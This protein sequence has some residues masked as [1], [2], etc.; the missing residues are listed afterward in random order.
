[1]L[2]HTKAAVQVR[3]ACDGTCARGGQDPRADRSLRPLRVGRA[4]Q[5]SVLPVV[6]LIVAGPKRQCAGIVCVAALWAKK[7]PRSSDNTPAPVAPIVPPSVAAAVQLQRAG[8]AVRV[9]VFVKA[10]DMLLTPSRRSSR[11]RRRCSAP[12]SSCYRLKNAEPSAV[13]SVRAACLVGKSSPCRCRTD[14][15]C[16][17][18]PP[19]RPCRCCSTQAAVQIRLPGDGQGAGGSE[20]PQTGDRRTIHDR[21][22]GQRQHLATGD[23]R[24][25]VQHD[26]V[27]DRVS[28]PLLPPAVAPRR[29]SKVPAPLIVPV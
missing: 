5:V 23:R 21:R 17:A 18:A 4:G 3:T 15:W 12:G 8:V 11:T 10:I 6:M 28:R 25:T 1:V 20:R 7:H 24:S 9:P 19:P 29:S 14:N 16:I 2:F 26:R 13:R 22:A 27:G